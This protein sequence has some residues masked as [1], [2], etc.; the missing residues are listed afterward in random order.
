M[1]K[2]KLNLQRVCCAPDRASLEGYVCPTVVRLYR[3]RLYSQK[4]PYTHCLLFSEGT[5]KLSETMYEAV[6]QQL[7]EA[8]S[9]LFDYF[10]STLHWKGERLVS[11][12]LIP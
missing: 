4:K 5:H 1:D 10:P 9:L 2:L 6:E 11:I 8:A 3:K 7:V 12:R